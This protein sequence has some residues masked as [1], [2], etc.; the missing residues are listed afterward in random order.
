MPS[1]IVHCIC[2]ACTAWTTTTEYMEKVFKY[3]PKKIHYHFEN[4]YS[5]LQIQMY[6]CALYIYIV[7]SSS[8]EVPKEGGFVEVG[9]LDHVLH[10]CLAEVLSGANLKHC[11]SSSC[12]SSSSW[13]SCHLVLHH[14]FVKILLCQKPKTIVN[15]T[16]SCFSNS[17]VFHRIVWTA[18]WCKI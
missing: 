7:S 1:Y 9:E 10:P 13:K 17:N 15:Q 2:H 14:S 8:P 4:S 5:L 16:F 6:I 11:S 12:C 3:I 18:M